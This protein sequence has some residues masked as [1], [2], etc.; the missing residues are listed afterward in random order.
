[1]WRGI[2]CAMFAVYFRYY[3]VHRVNIVFNVLTATV[4]LHSSDFD[5][6]FLELPD[7]LVF[8]AHSSAYL[9]QAHTR[10][11]FSFL[12]IFSTFSLTFDEASLLISRLTWGGLVLIIVELE[13]GF[14]KNDSR[15]SCSNIDC[16][17]FLVGF[18]F[19]QLMRPLFYL[20]AEFGER[21][22][23]T[24][25]FG[26]RFEEGRWKKQTNDAF[27]KSDRKES[28]RSSSFRILLSIRSVIE[29][30]IRVKVRHGGVAVGR[31]RLRL[32]KLITIHLDIWSKYSPLNWFRSG[33]EVYNKRECI[34]KANTFSF[35]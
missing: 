32:M 26:K 3:F 28:G 18:S 9:L 6:A 12:G 16:Q 33:I 2:S 24:P 5:G 35:V 34:C 31:G 25:I 7:D 27:R 29:N 10:R 17:L 30:K 20:P 4:F 1:M 13:T 11:C 15:K 22:F 8:S 23:L 21:W 14:P 19:R